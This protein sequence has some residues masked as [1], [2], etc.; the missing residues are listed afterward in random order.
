MKK[1][2]VLKAE[3]R[4]SRETPKRKKENI[5]NFKNPGTE[6]RR[7]KDQGKVLLAMMFR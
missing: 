1:R 2:G 4:L 7:D 5:G 6:Y 3:S